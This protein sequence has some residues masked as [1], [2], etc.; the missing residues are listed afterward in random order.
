M[1]TQDGLEIICDGEHLDGE[2]MPDILKKAQDLLVGK[3]I[4]TVGYLVDAGRVWPVLVLD[5][6]S[7]I[8]AM[9]DDEGNGPGSIHLEDAGGETIGGL[10][11]T[12][13]G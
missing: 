6:G 12:R 3:R 4:E 2:A 11:E 5:D 7:R 8:V 10:C 1:E 13:K 9:Y